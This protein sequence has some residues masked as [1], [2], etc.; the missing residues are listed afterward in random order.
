MQAIR[1]CGFKYTDFEIDEALLTRE[2]APVELT[3]RLLEESELTAYQA[4][5]PM[6]NAF[7]E[8]GR[9]KLPLLEQSIRLCAAVGI[10]SVVVHA[11]SLVGNTK[12]EFLERN[13]EFYN[14][15]LPFCEETGVILLAENIGRP[16]E[17][18]FLSDGQ[19][20]RELLD[21]VNHPLFKA[22]WD[23]GHANH[24]AGKSQYASLLALGDK[25]HALHVHDNTGYF[26]PCYR[27]HRIDMHTM[28]YVSLYTD[29]NFDEVLLGLKH[30]GYKGTF[31]FEVVTGCPRIRYTPFELDGVVHDKLSSP[32][33]ELWKQFNKTLYAT[34]KYMLEAYDMFEG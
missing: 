26:P 10:P 2:Q 25:L 15:L 1:D 30:I 27:Q 19:E 6:F 11:N 24:H 14:S 22:C 31:N 17:S 8:E 9:A 33:L 16:D 18:F 32:S 20:L 28:P 29:V 23:V 12:Q 21:A 4:H 5:A 3:R 34:G 7:T 13:V